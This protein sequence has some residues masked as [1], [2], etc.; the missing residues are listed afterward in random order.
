MK[1]NAALMRRGMAMSKKPELLSN[2]SDNRKLFDKEIWD[3]DDCARFLQKS[4]A[5]V[6]RLKKERN[7][8]YR[9][10]GTLYFFPHEVR[11]WVEK[12]A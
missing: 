2:T 10:N 11:E 1:Y 9:K 8:P 7:L 6:Y 5:H 4:K 12:G 3:M